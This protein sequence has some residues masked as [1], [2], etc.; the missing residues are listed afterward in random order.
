MHTQQD[1]IDSSSLVMT[2]S[3]LSPLNMTNN[4]MLQ[5]RKI[6]PPTFPG[7]WIEDNNDE[8]DD[9]QDKENTQQQFV[10]IVSVAPP[11]LSDQIIATAS[12]ASDED[13]EFLK[14]TIANLRKEQEKLEET[15][16]IV[17]KSIQIVARKRIIAQT[18][19][20]LKKTQKQQQSS[21]ASAATA[22]EEEDVY[23][24]V[25]SEFMPTQEEMKAAGLDGWEWVS[26]Y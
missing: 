24:V 16:H 23:I 18:N 1:N 20:H 12:S 11:R 21:E 25:Q 10:K 3:V 2:S 13:I 15:D 17:K 4:A 26:A 5:R 19:S 7:A 22:D 8:D 9:D 14:Q 6:K